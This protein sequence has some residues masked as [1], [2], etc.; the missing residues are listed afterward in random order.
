MIADL[1]TAVSDLE[2]A[3]RLS[4]IQLGPEVRVTEMILSEHPSGPS[5]SSPADDVHAALLEAAVMAYSRSF[6][7][8]RSALVKGPRRRLQEF[9]D[10]LSSA[11]RAAHDEVMHMRDQHVAHRVDRTLTQTIV[12]K[13][14]TAEGEYF[15]VMPLLVTQ[16]GRQLTMEQVGRLTDQL[17]PVV[18]SVLQQELIALNRAVRPDPAGQA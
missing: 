8:G 9:V 18:R 4:L 7:S 17:L 2:Y 14:T 16:T 15:G 10:G 13:M 3:Q 11:D 12:A 1:T 5:E 6:S